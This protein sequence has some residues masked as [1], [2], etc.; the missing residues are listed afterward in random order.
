[1]DLT[2]QLLIAMPGLDDPRFD[3]SVMFLCAHSD[4]GAMGLMLNKRVGAMTLDEVFETVGIEAGNEA[5][6]APVHFGGPVETERG[7]VLHRDATRPEAESLRIPDGYMLTATRDILVELAEGAGPAPFHFALGYAGWGG[8]QLENEIAE[9]S[10]L[11]ANA[12]PE[13]VFGAAHE[14]LWETALRSIGIDPMSLSG[15]AGRA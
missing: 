7:F 2:G 1:M 8:G 10:W 4:A 13:L 12:T 14:T 6:R 15:A 11:T 9:N 3:R 5:A